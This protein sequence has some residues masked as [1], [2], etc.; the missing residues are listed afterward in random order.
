MTEKSI[1]S[2]GVD[3]ITESRGGPVDLFEKNCTIYIF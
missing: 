2:D 3:N 1:I